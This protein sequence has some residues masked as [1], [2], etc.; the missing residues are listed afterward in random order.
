MAAFV[1]SELFHVRRGGISRVQ[2]RVVCAMNFNFRHY[3]RRYRARRR[4]RVEFPLFSRH[5]HSRNL[6][7]P[8][9]FSLVESSIAFNGRA[10]FQRGKRT[11][12]HLRESA[13]RLGP[14]NWKQVAVESFLRRE[15]SWKSKES[16]G[17]SSWLPSD[18]GITNVVIWAPNRISENRNREGGI[19]QES[20][21][22]RF[23]RNIADG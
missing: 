10:I 4:L 8:L 14:G 6:S 3:F 20:S 18:S 9:A 7:E 22:F 15:W 12:S 23:V 17:S 13:T 16:T 2:R 19:S 5:F 1:V 11:N 21:P